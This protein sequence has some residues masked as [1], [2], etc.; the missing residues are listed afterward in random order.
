MTIEKHGNKWRISEMVSGQRYRLSV[1]YKPSKREASVLIN[2]LIQSQDV[3]VSGCRTFYD[4]GVAYIKM[5]SNV[6]SPTTYRE[7]DRTLNA[8]SKDFRNLK[9]S[10]ISQLDIQKE[11]NN[12]SKDHAP[13][14]VRNLH[15]FISAVLSVFRPNMHLHTTLPQ[16]VRFDP[17]TP[18]DS[19]IKSVLDD[20]KGTKYEIP[21]RLGCYG[22]RRSEIC[23]LTSGDL[24]GNMLSINKAC[25]INIDKEWVIK[26]YGK[27]SESKRE[28]YIDD[29]LAGLI[30]E[31]EG[32]LYNGAVT[33]L[34]DYLKKVQK[35]CEIPDFRFHDL[36]A[37]YASM[38]H[39]M[40]IPDQYIMANGG[41]SSPYVMQRVYRR[42]MSDKQKEMNQLF[43]KSFD[44]LGQSNDEKAE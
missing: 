28:I 32:K 33:Y 16:K 6:L 42:A 3:P 24:N 23:A 18:T 13:K 29:Y 17:Y 34:R 40:G 25:V 35:R 38:A 12:Y 41:W 14:S 37:Y 2:D 43:A 7:Y 30:R 11:I 10:Q 1:D 22:L 15:G 36:R 20:V 8:L 26:E 27:T 19:D 39:A 4:A 21:F 31:K 9:I 5:K 44:G